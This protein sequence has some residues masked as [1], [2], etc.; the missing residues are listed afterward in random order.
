MLG[1]MSGGGMGFLT[2]PERRAEF[3]EGILAIMREAKNELAAA[4]PFAMDPV[5][6]D[7][8]INPVGSTAELRADASAVMPTRYYALQV[9]EL[10]RR[11]PDDLPYLRR[12]ELDHVTAHCT[13]PVDAYGML[14]TVISHLFRVSG[15]AAHDEHAAWEEEAARIKTD[16]GFD[17]IQHEQLRAD[18]RAGRIGLAHNRLP[19]D[20]EIE[21]VRDGDVIPYSAGDRARGEA[22]LREGRVAVLTL[23]GGVGS[24]WTTGAGVIKALNPFVLLAGHHRNFIDIHLAKTRG[25]EETFGAPVPHIISTSY[26]THEPIAQY[27]QSKIQN[28]KSKIVLSPGQSI[29]QRLIP[30]VRDLV[31]LWEEMPQELLDAQKQKVRTA[32]RAAL[33]EW[34]RA[35]GEGSDY[36]DNLPSQRFS[37]PGH[38]YEVANLLRNGTLVR[39]LAEQPQ[40]ETI[41][42]HNVDT[43]GANLDPIALGAHLA[44][45]GACTFEVIPRWV[46]DRGG[47]LARINGRVRL[48]EGLAQPR[49]EDEL[50]LRYYNSLTTWIQI[51]PLLALF[52]LTRADLAGPAARAH[53]ADAVRRVARRVPTYVTIK[54]VKRR[55]G[56]GQEDI[57]PVAQ[58]EKLWGDIS[59]LP[60]L[61]CAYLAVPRL[62]GQQLKDP[63]QLD[64]WANDGSKEYVEGLCR[65]GEREE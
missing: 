27:I 62:R 60:D 61:P 51:D 43:L 23:A 41:L 12:A 30:M 20:T 34:A 37:P 11:H 39:L 18:L 5:V 48:L 31:F 36:T 15:P 64:P 28:Q 63:A 29:A 16:N 53:I 56:H 32:G 24:R 14:R 47:G 13:D 59:A 55:W 9:P 58:F 7:F 42:L 8:A 10:V 17:A 2:A 35:Q 54:D 26:L 22:A 46:G 50:R 1:G 38:W 3:R 33:M 49:E 44:G 21:D 6:Y 4:L 45:G 19:V 40:V 57:F 52:G 25:T 65:F